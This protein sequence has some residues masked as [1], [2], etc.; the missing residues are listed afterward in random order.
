M[1]NSLKISQNDD[2][3]FTLEWDKNDPEWSF[4]NNMTSVQI[5]E[6]VRESVKEELKKYE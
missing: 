4:L 5:Q 6:M 3:T 2:K 1:K